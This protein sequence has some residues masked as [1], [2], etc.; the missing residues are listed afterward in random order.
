[1]APKIVDGSRNSGSDLGSSPCGVLD[2]TS[3]SYHRR[4][5]GSVQ[6]PTSIPTNS[7]ADMSEQS[8]ALTHLILTE[9]C[10]TGL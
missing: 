3:L 1:M 5:I 7:P 4:Q 10:K 9:E 6:M 2:S 8:L